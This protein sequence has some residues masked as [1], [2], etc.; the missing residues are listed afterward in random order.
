MQENTVILDFKV[1]DDKK[2]GVRGVAP[3]VLRVS[4]A[5]SK[6]LGL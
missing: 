3:V 6:W 5:C 4:P 1:P 2:A